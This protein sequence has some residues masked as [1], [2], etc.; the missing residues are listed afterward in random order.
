M[1]ILCTNGDI[2]VTYSTLEHHHYC[3]STR[4]GIYHTE[5]IKTNNT[6]YIELQTLENRNLKNIAYINKKKSMIYQ[7]YSYYGECSIDNSYENI[8]SY[9]I[10]SIVFDNNYVIILDLE[11]IVVFIDKIETNILISDETHILANPAYW[12]PTL[13]DFYF[14]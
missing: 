7:I 6:D 11:K 3:I 10:G 4:F 1:S 13:S 14:S 8:F 12:T 9:R 5:K 2:I